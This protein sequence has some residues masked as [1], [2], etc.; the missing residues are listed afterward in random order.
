MG[1][2]VLATAFTGGCAALTSAKGSADSAK[3]QADDAKG[4]ADQGKEQVKGAKGKDGKGGGDDGAA[5]DDDTRL[6]AKDGADQRADQRH[7]RLPRRANDWRKFTLAGQAG[8]VATFELHWDERV[9]NL[10]IDVF[11]KFGVN[12]GKS[13]RRIE[14]Q[15]VQ[16]GAGAA[17]TT[18]GSTTSASRGRPRPTAA[19]TR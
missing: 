9:A 8:P 14:G 4:Q 13:P 6:D 3:G 15:S 18:R 17:S 10:D 5:G 7:G 2:C 12:V 19:S 11:D 16:E 1:A